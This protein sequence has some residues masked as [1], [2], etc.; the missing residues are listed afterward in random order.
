MLNRRTLTPLH[1]VLWVGIGCNKGTSKELI[2]AAIRQV[3]R[4]NQLE[5][6]AIAGIAT[7]DIKANEA[8]LIE[9]C[10]ERNLP[11][12]TFSADVLRTVCVPNPNIAVS[13]AV[14]TPSV[15]EA[16]ALCAASDLTPFLG[17]NQEKLFIWWGLGVRLLVSK[18]I[19]RSSDQNL[20]SIIQNQKGT[21]TIAVAEATQLF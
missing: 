12:K 5:E 13:E 3:F 16:A 1:P 20:K 21:V 18:Q 15:A 9:L 19:F 17:E 8:G 14:L 7:I 2:Q 4:E 6:G 10:R 11:L